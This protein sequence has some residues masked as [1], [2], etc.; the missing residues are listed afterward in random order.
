[1]LDRDL[2]RHLNDRIRDVAAAFV[3][4]DDLPAEFMCE[5]GCET[6]VAMS[7]PDYDVCAHVWA[8]DHEPVT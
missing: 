2:V 6:Y 3:G 7:L 5:C 1:L 4:I 8:V